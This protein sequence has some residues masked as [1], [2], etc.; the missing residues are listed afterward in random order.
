MKLIN[1]PRFN[2]AILKNLEKMDKKPKKD[3]LKIKRLFPDKSLYILGGY[4]RDS[5]LNVLNGYNFPINDL[6]ILANDINFTKKIGNFGSSSGKKSLSRFGGMKLKYEGGFSID[7]FSMNNITYLNENPNLKKN[8]ENVLNGVD[9]SISAFAYNL[10]DNQIYSHDFAMEDMHNLEINVLND[11]SLI[12]STLSRLIIHS[13]K[14]KFKL[15]QKAISYIK[16]NYRPEIDKD[17]FNFLKYKENEFLFPLVKSEL[18]SIAKL[19]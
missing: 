11:D 7:V 8:I 5:I 15:G 10:E 18:S 13:N 19:H 3:F 1:E 6:D 14:T 9:L 4:V 12:P 2:M 16:Q 17:I